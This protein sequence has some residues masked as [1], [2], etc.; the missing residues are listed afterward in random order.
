[1][2]T[3]Q[4]GRIPA[5]RSFADGDLVRAR[6]VQFEDRDADWVTGRL[7]V[8]RSEPDDAW[9]FDMVWIS[10]GSSDEPVVVDSDTIEPVPP[11]LAHQRAGS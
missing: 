1:V 5:Q 11:R 7:R 6:P 8:V 10:D 4:T 9:S 2:T 3:R